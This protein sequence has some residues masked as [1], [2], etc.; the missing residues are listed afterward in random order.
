MWAQS[1]G[2]VELPGSP[3]CSAF[4]LDCA[5]HPGLILIIPNHLGTVL[6]IRDSPGQTRMCGHP[7]HKALEGEENFIPCLWFQEL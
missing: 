4:P 7:T 5:P 6:K 2:E 3:C 1:G